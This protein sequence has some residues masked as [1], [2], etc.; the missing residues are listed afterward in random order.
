MPEGPGARLLFA[1][2]RRDWRA[3]GVDATAVAAGERADLRLVDEVAPA[4]LA[5]WYLRHFT[6]DA[7]I[8]CSPEADAAME[9]ARMAP[10]PV[11]R[12]DSLAAADRL[13]TDLAAFI[14][15][16]APVRWSLVSPRLTGWQPNPFGV[17]FVGSLVAPPR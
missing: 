15:I 16:A 6:C 3:I 1:H 11:Q 5:S 4:L 14:P 8:V 12:R 10:D 2:L 13:L 9:A 17:R 7:S